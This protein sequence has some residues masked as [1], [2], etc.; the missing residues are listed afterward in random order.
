MS[1]Y[2]AAVIDP[3]L[4]DMDMGMGST[5]GMKRK[6]RAV[7]E[8][9]VSQSQAQTQRS[10]RMTRRQ[11]AAAAAGYVAG[12]HQGEPSRGEEE[13]LMSYEWA[14]ENMVS[15]SC[16]RD[17]QRGASPLMPDIMTVDSVTSVGFIESHMFRADNRNALAADRRLPTSR[18]MHPLPRCLQMPHGARRHPRRLRTRTPCTLPLPPLPRPPPG[19]P[20]QARAQLTESRTSPPQPLPRTPLRHRGIR[21]LTDSR[22]SGTRAS[23]RTS[24]LHRRGTRLTLGS[25]ASTQRT[26]VPPPGA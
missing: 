14:R 20:R 17:V 3:A 11:A 8:A 22:R 24:R 1:G 9:S 25:G 26:E 23:H 21:T 12:S 6:A 7:A 10:P 2:A 4:Q 13:N 5:A 18:D 16:R 15:C 19:Q